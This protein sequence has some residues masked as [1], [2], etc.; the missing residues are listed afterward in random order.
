VRVESDSSRRR[1]SDSGS[2]EIDGLV[3]LILLDLEQASQWLE[4]CLNSK[5]IPSQSGCASSALRSNIDSNIQCACRC[6]QASV[7][8]ESFLSRWNSRHD[9]FLRQRPSCL[10]S[11]PCHVAGSKAR[12]LDHPD[13]TPE[14]PT[15][16]RDPRQARGVPGTRFE[17]LS[18]SVNNV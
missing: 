16:L 5:L 10:T 18:N 13:G 14:R 6:S 11:P 8:R 1:G 2:T 3:E 17:A 15:D 4:A 7:G 9:S 12:E